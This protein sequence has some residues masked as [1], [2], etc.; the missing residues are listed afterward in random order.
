VP[1]CEVSITLSR[2]ATEFTK[3][4]KE[5]GLWYYKSMGVNY[6]KNNVVSGF[7]LA[8]I[9]IATIVMTM[10]M[11][12]VIGF[13]HSGAE[14]WTRGQ[15]SINAQNYKRAV[16][17]L[18]KADMLK[19]TSITDPYASATAQITSNTMHYF[20]DTPFGNREF[21]IGIV[22]DHRL[23]RHISGSTIEEKHYNLTIARHIASF[24]AT[25]I[26]TWTIKIFLE[27]G[28]EPDA[29]GY[30]DTISSDTMIFTTPQAG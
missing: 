23:E 24:S 28:S 25:R 3:K 11:A 18:I 17:E 16:F 12:T 6:R 22:G 4:K 20:M 9:M 13:I 8:E 2:Q 21:I 29:Y 26:S 1:P 10:I 14:L 15:E 30:M 27:V 7:S 19:A 5:I